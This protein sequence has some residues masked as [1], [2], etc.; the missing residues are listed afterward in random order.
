[1]AL[2]CSLFTTN[3]STYCYMPH[4][5][6]K[7]V[8]ND[9]VL[10][11]DWQTGSHAGFRSTAEPCFVVQTLLVCLV[12]C[13]CRELTDSHRPELQQNRNTGHAEHPLNR[14]IRRYAVF[15]SISGRD[16]QLAHTAPVVTGFYDDYRAA[17][18]YEGS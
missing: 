13:R 16:I 2:P 9:V 8:S 3:W 4:S 15:L 18:F 1:M 12:T 6:S 17:A 5:N 7:A 14:N 11:T 10:L